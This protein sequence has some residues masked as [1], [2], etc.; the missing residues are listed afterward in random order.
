MIRSLHQ[1]HHYHVLS[2]TERVGL[3]WAYRKVYK[4]ICTY[5]NVPH[6]GLL[7]WCSD[8][9]EIQSRIHLDNLIRTYGIVSKRAIRLRQIPSPEISLSW[10]YR[11]KAQQ[12]A[13]GRIDSHHLVLKSLKFQRSSTISYELSIV[14]FMGDRK[15]VG[16][17]M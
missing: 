5:A 13:N 1:C 14:V 7:S 17:Y 16:T 2:Q 4:R 8:Q 12:L 15:T 3:W 9:I 11:I 6:Q 10:H